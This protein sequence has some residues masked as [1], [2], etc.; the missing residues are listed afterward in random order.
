MKLNILIKWELQTIEYALSNFLS[1]AEKAAK[2][3]SVQGDNGFN[4]DGLMTEAE[5][6]KGARI[7]VLNSVLYEMNALMEW[8]LFVLGNWDL[9]PEKRSTP[10]AFKRSRSQLIR[11]V[12]GYFEIAL[13]NLPGYADVE[14]L[15]DEVNALKH[16][17]GMIP[18]GDRSNPYPMS[19]SVQMSR[20]KAMQYL[21]STEL[22]LNAL[23]AKIKPQIKQIPELFD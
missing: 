15:K 12:E 11:E 3:A 19:M 1:Y 16:R 6:A 14:R 4:P 23:W 22:F 7:L 2:K 20:E 17:G 8:V 13:K 21:Q 9:P 18:H 10:S 5:L